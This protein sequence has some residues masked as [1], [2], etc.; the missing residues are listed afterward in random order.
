MRRNADPTGRPRTVFLVASSLAAALASSGCLS[1]PLSEGNAAQPHLERKVFNI[2][3]DDGR[4]YAAKALKA[5]SYRITGVERNGN[6]TVVEGRNDAEKLSSRLTVTCAGDG[7]TPPPVTTCSF[8]PR[9]LR[10]S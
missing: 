8:V 9:V 1:G 4:R 2:S 6:D 3:C 10:E 7:V 5:R